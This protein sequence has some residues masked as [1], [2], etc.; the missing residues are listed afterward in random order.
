MQKGRIEIYIK[1]AKLVSLSE[2]FFS[3]KKIIS[4]RIEPIWI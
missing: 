3:D 1:Y 4:I 2:R